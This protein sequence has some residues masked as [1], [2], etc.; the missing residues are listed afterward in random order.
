MKKVLGVIGGLGPLATACFMERILDM[1]DAKAE[2]EN[3]DMIIYNFPS[4]PDRTRFILEQSQDNPFPHLLKIATALEQQGAG[5]IAMPC[6]TA[7]YFHK[8]L[9]NA[10]SVPFLN[11]VAETAA[12]LKNAGV[13]RVGIMA[14]AGT[15]QSGIFAQELEIAGITPVLPS[16]PRQA[17]IMHLIYNNLK[18]GLPMEENRF[19][20]VQQELINAGCQVIILG[21]TELSLISRSFPPDGNF[22]DVIDVLARQAVLSCGG[23]LKPEYSDLLKGVSLLANQHPCVFGI[24]G[25]APSQ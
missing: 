5:C 16:E 8:Q 3:I 19:R 24:H 9:Q 2:Q 22:L 17:D 7:H 21:C 11:L 6:I 20:R 4:T 23:R 25:Q 13:R 12:V 1:T 10:V 18:L 14:T 15:I